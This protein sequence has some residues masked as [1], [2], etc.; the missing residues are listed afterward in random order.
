MPTICLIGADARHSRTTK[1]VAHD[2]DGR[3]TAFG[4]PRYRDESVGSEFLQAR[5]RGRMFSL[6]Y[7]EEEMQMDVMSFRISA[8][9]LR[10]N[11]EPLATVDR[12]VDECRTRL[13][14]SAALEDA[15]HREYGAAS[16]SNPPNIPFG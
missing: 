2:Q 15:R 10:A 8:K 9:W 12:A 5:C 16:R 4:I 7:V 11:I 1:Y 3:L 13:S 6:I 14:F